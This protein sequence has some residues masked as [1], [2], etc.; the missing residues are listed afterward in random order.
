MPVLGIC[1]ASTSPQIQNKQTNKK[2][3]KAETNDNNVLWRMGG[4]RIMNGIVKEGNLPHFYD[5]F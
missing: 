5:I 4:D 2:K 3:N 1:L